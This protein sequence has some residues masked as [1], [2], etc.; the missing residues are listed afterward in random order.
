MLGK[1]LALLKKADDRCPFEIT[2][3]YM[4]NT[5]GAGGRDLTGRC[6]LKKGHTG[7]CTNL[8][9]IWTDRS[10]WNTEERC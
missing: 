1:L 10:N 8:K 9:A 4:K 7:A 5:R 3:E 6:L 2:A